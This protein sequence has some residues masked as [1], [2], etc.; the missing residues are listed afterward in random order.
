MVIFLLIGAAVSLLSAAT[1]AR[2]LEPDQIA[3]VVNRNVPE[4]MELARF[5]AQARGV[6]D[7]RVIE[8]DLPIED[9]IAFEN[10]A[11]EVAVPLRDALKS[12]GLEKQIRCL[13]T[14]YGVPLRIAART[15]SA[16]EASELGRIRAELQRTQVQI[17]TSVQRLE[18]LATQLDLRFRPLP[19]TSADALARRA[20]HVTRAIHLAA[21]AISDET[22][23]RAILQQIS[24][25]SRPLSFPV[26]DPPT[27][28][29]ADRAATSAP[30]DP[31]D[32]KALLSQQSD[33]SARERL[34][35]IARR[36]SSPFAYE[37]VLQ[38]QYVLLNPEHTDSALDS[39]LSLLWQTDYARAGWQPNPLGYP[40]LANPS[41]P[42]VLMVSRL[43]APAPQIV[44]DII[45]ASM[46]TERA[47]LRGKFV[48]D[49]RGIPPKNPAGA[50]DA[51]G[52]FDQRL[53]TLAAIIKSRT[54]LELVHD[55]GPEVLPANSV[56]DV[57]LYCGWYSVSHYVPS[58]KFVP[59]AVAFH[60]ASFEL[61][62]LRDPNNA[63]WCR[64]LLN[65]GVAATLGPVAEPI[66]HAFP[67]PDDFFP[68]LLTGRLPLVEV[69]WRTVPM[70]SWKLS[71]IGDPLYVPFKS[72]PAIRIEDLPPRLRAMFSDASTT[73]MRP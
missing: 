52:A 45:A 46:S 19:A 22:K 7:G 55:D 8:L 6:P 27:T 38:E 11:P 36:S 51:F 71:L 28:N 17:V 32:A 15:R 49:S 44:R 20:D 58:M 60:V 21:R 64:G 39:E 16:E 43:D 62:G 33:P 30:V 25:L 29:P 18:V 3:L 67:V 14:F 65:D 61:T 47:G 12:R 42:N 34:R 26:G 40:F 13:V 63:G 50:D 54:N 72:N 31:A 57:A 59:G 56:T 10:F 2:A 37:K 70:T 1:P 73:Q 4:S 9:Q 23:R 53:R 41:P 69:Y 24:D 48:I 5:Y 68:L 35:I 66:L